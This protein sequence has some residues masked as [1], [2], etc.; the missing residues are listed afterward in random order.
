MPIASA[1]TAVSP[2]LTPKL[3]AEA[4]AWVDKTLAGLTLEKKIGQIVC[5]DIAGGYI[6]ADDPPLLSG[7]PLPHCPAASAPRLR[8]PGHGHPSDLYARRRYRLAP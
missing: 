8:G 5:S 3:S 6:A 4:A 7:L 2:Q 1:Q